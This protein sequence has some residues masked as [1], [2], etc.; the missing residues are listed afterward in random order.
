M[1][2]LGIPNLRLQDGEDLKGTD[3]EQN[4]PSL[5]G[6]PGR[7]VT[8]QAHASEMLSK[9]REQFQNVSCP[10]HESHACYWVSHACRS[11][12]GFVEC[13]LMPYQ[14]MCAGEQQ[15]QVLTILVTQ[16]LPLVFKLHMLALGL[17]C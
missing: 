11:S 4:E 7:K 8:D 14:K 16:S 17:S 3:P 2:V 5:S 9:I 15:H 1:K 12:Q 6:L 13:S 10:L